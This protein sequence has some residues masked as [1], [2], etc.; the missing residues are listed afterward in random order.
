MAHTVTLL[1]SAPLP[2]NE[3]PGGLEYKLVATGSKFTTGLAVAKPGAGESWHKH[4]KEVEETYYIVKG[5]GR[6]SWKADGT[7]HTLDFS[8]GDALYL[9]HGL[10]NEF[11]NTGNDELMIVFTITNAAKARE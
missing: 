8:S 1:K 6:I 2:W 7:V 4:T 10:E 11:V 5:Q 9:P 3:L